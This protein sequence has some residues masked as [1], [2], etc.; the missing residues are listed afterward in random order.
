MRPASD[1]PSPVPLLHALVKK[2]PSGLDA[3]TI[4]RLLGREYATLM[5]ELSGQPGH[6][7][8]LDLLLPLMEL[9][10]SDEPLHWM[11]RERG[12]IYVSVPY[13]VGKSELVEGLVASVKEFGEFAAETGQDIA[14]GR[15]PADQL[16]RIQKEGQEALTAILAVMDM[17]C[18]AHEEQYGQRK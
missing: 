5:S 16:Q 2:A 9:T 17:A 6:K 10:G 18:K 13:T 3:A 7:L 14:D 12:G 4:A 15:L 8:G 1:Y 11:A